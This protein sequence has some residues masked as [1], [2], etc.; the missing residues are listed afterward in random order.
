MVATP[1]K[2]YY[3]LPTSEGWKAELA[4]LVDPLRISYPAGTALT[5]VIDATVCAG[6]VVTT[7]QAHL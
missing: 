3:S 4:W 7:E 1:V 5:T 2:D 6:C